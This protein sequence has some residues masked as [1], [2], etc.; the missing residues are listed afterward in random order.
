MNIDN[1][2]LQHAGW[3]GTPEIVIIVIVVILL[4]GGRKIPELMKG[5]GKGIKEFKA[6]VADDNDAENSEDNN[7]NNKKET[8]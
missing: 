2:I 7:N 5:I 6:G 4:F 8:K 3:L 1:T